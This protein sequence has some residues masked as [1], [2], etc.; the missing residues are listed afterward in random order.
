MA[1]LL[2][3]IYLVVAT[4]VAVG[5]LAV[6]ATTTNDLDRSGSRWVNWSMLVVGALFLLALAAG[7]VT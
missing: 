7:F 3:T 1:G 4:L 6:V 5:G 2:N